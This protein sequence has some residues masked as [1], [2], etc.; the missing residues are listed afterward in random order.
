MRSYL[1]TKDVEMFFDLLSDACN[2]R[3]N[4]QELI[5]FLIDAS[6]ESKKS[7]EEKFVSQLD[8]KSNEANEENLAR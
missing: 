8:E 3:Y 6:N 7:M 1:P 2:E 4:L 5:C